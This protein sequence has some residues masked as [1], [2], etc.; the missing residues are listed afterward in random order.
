MFPCT[1]T[2]S[3]YF[4][5]GLNVV[6]YF[7]I[8]D[9]QMKPALPFSFLGNVGLLYFLNILFSSSKLLAHTF[10]QYLNW[11]FLI[12]GGISLVGKLNEEIYIEFI[13][14]HYS[15]HVPP[16][17]SEFSYNRSKIFVHL[18]KNI[19]PLIYG[20]S[21]VMGRMRKELQ[22]NWFAKYFVNISKLFL[23]YFFTISNLLRNPS[24]GQVGRGVTA[25]LI[26][27]G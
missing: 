19:F 1:Y 8:M 10:C 5:N 2:Y 12:C 21:S 18:L 22:P 14:P 6:K 15:H 4:L 16:I 24:G 13:Y 9:K 23:K 27:I 11:N 25:S 3:P 17:Y 26:G 20:V 7:S